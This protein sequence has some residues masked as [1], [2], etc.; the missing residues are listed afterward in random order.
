[1]SRRGYTARKP[2]KQRACGKRR[3]RDQAQAQS[4]LRLI[5]S[6]ARDVAPTRAYPCDR[7]KGWHLTKQA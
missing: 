7:C 2:R 1:M 4:A 6:S 3:F 5:G